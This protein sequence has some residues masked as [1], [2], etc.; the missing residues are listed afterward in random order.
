MDT[1]S[2]LFLGMRTIMFVGVVVFV[3]LASDSPLFFHDIPGVETMGDFECDELLDSSLEASYYQMCLEDREAA[4]KSIYYAGVFVMIMFSAMH[5][6]S[7]AV[8]AI[9]YS[10]FVFT[11]HKQYETTWLGAAIGFRV[12]AAKIG[13]ARENTR[14]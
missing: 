4:V 3:I 8:F 5:V 12:G 2:K 1:D 6:L 7:I 9:L 11:L 13:H 14:K 10:L